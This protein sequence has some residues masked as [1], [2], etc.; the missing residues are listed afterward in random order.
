MGQF[1]IASLPLTVSQQNFREIKEKNDEQKAKR[2]ELFT[3]FD[4]NG[5]GYLSL[6][7]VDKGMRDVLQ[8]DE[9]FDCKQAVN[10]AFHFAK[11]KSQ[12]ESKHGDDLL[13]FRE[14]RLFLQTLR[15]FFEY[16]QAFERIDTGDDNRVSK[17]EFCSDKIKESITKWVGE[18]EDFE[19]EF[20]KI[21]A[22]GGGQILFTEFVDWALEKNLDI[23]DDIDEAEVEAEKVAEEAE[24][25]EEAA[26]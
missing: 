16:Y 20:E 17:E 9:L 13:E 21:D 1:V 25:T 10:R 15:Q 12:G 2:K 11:N 6:A 26:E 4:P 22:N 19:A 7:E 3:Q 18:I 24:A 8:S 5:N 14:F 23:E